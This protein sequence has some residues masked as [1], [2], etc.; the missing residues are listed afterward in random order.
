MTILPTSD[1]YVSI[2]PREERQWAAWLEV[3]GSPD[4]GSDPRFATKTDRVA[5]WDVLHAAMSRW[6]RHSA[7]QWMT[8]PAQAAHVPSFPLREPAEQ[9]ASPQLV[10]R[11]FYRLL[12]ID[13][14]TV[15]TPGRR[16][17]CIP[18]HA[19]HYP[20]RI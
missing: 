6:S 1:G 18:K 8:D 13:G 9:L 10:H 2:S 4:W 14:R 17:V 12:E 16:L 7:K 19:E 11:D 20:K 3:M 5:N 15:E